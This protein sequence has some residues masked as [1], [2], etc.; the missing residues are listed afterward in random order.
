ML[1]S[2]IHDVKKRFQVNNVV[3]DTNVLWAKWSPSTGLWTVKIQN[4]LTGEETTK[5]CNVVIS[6]VGGLREPNI[7]EF[8]QNTEFK[9]DVFHSARW[10]HNVEIAGRDVVVVGNGCSASQIIPVSIRL[11][12]ALQLA[13]YSF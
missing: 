4:K 11:R 2:D 9:G 12:Y 5:T 10:N 1:S 3:F 8:V 13:N 6:A 7:P